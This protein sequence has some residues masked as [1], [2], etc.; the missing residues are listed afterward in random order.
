MKAAK[1]IINT[2]HKAGFNHEDSY[3]R[4]ESTKLLDA[5]AE[6]VNILSSD[7]NLYCTTIYQLVS[8]TKGTEYRP[9]ARNYGHGGF[10]AAG[11]G[12][13]DANHHLERINFKDFE[14]FELHLDWAR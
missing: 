4:L 7:E 6:T 11:C 12:S 9:V 14:L 3:I 13:W 8:G 5:M 10:Y 1:Y 2:D